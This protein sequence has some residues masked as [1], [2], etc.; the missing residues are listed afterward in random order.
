MRTVFDIGMYDGADSAYYLQ[1]GYRVVAVEAN[2]ALAQ[3]AAETFAA[4]IASG[5][6]ICVNA[7]IST[8]RDPVELLLSGS[9][10]G[11]SSVFSDRVAQKRPI[12]SVTVPSMTMQNLLSRYG[13]PFYVKVDIEGA[14]R[15]CVLSLNSENRPEYLSF[16]VG[17]DVEEL[18]E[19]A[20]KIG[21]GKFKIVN[22]TSFRELAK[23]DCLYDRIIQRF[24]RELG[25]A[26]CRQIRR[27]G[28]FFVSGHSSGPGP[29]ESDGKWYSAKESLSRWRWAKATG[30]LSGWYDIHATL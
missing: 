14:D 11:S 26:D 1:S 13:A 21:F 24:V 23:Q 27:A 28:R 8:S 19:H 5:Q 10:L 18:V 15:I 20:R 9:D 6:M 17:D 3:R 4:E 22:Q 7:A 16:E 2:P 29:W 25:H 30:A 12:G